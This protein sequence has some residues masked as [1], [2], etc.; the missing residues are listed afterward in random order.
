MLWVRIADS[1]VL[2]EERSLPS[3]GDG[4]I[5]VKMHSCGL[6]GSD[7]EKVYG[8]YAMQSA[9]VGHEPAGEVVKVG[10]DVNKVDIGDRIFVHHHVSCYSCR[11]CLHGDYTMCDMYQRSNID[12]CGLSEEF[13]VPKW[14]I[15]R[16][17]IF[18][19]PD[20]VS[21]EEA[22]LIEPLACCIRGFN[23]ISIKDGDNVA[24][25]GAGP[26]GM[27]H[28]LLAERAGANKIFVIDINEFRLKFA[29]RYQNTLTFNPLQTKDISERIK[30]LSNDIGV[31]STIIATG[32]IGALDQALTFTR[33]GG[34]ILLFGVPPKNARINLELSKI[35]SNEFILLPSYGASE[36]ETS[37][38]LALITDKSINVQPL[39]THRFDIKQSKDAFVCAHEAVGVMKV[40]VTS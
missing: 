11:Y 13:V 38:A 21:Y 31:D 30:E 39:V 35:Y 22:A 37:Q 24:I 19:L 4:D 14:N 15:S 6:C 40:V 32:N 9:R 18:K 33:R 23:K 10:K 36:V 29:L 7:L 5:L 1:G 16:G 28:L 17:G 2:V 3:L 26:T 8:K 20:N 34:R 25:I 27:M 12:P